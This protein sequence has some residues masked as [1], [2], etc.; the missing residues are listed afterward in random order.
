MRGLR[1]AI[2][3]PSLRPGSSQREVINWRDD[4]QVLERAAP[5]YWSGK[6]VEVVKTLMKDFD[7]RTISATRELFPLDTAWHWFEEPLFHIVGRGE[8]GTKPIL[9]VSAVSWAYC[10]GPDLGP[11]IAATAWCVAPRW[12]QQVPLP[13]LWWCREE[14]TNMDVLQPLPE[15]GFDETAEAESKILGRFL[16]CA[17][18]F[19]RQKLLRV[20][21][22]PLERH[23]RKRLQEG[24]SPCEDRDGVHIITSYSPTTPQAQIR[25]LSTV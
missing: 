3:N 6:C 4:L 1:L 24:M 14:G 8:G 25:Q 23:A 2:R 17:G 10:I 9:P 20:E 16:A 21:Q 13:T 7:L 18:T 5:F 19:L 12:Q 11:Q 15:F 22:V